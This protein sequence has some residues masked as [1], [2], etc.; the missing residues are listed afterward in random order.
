MSK[1]AKFYRRLP[2][3]Q[4][5]TSRISSAQRLLKRKVFPAFHLGW[6]LLYSLFFAVCHIFADVRSD[7]LSSALIKATGFSAPH[8]RKFSCFLPLLAGLCRVCLLLILS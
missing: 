5:G 1:P 8:K 7:R 6:M 4:H 2:T 3:P